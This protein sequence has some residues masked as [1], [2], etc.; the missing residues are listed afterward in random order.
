MGERLAWRT[1]CTQALLV[2]TIC[3]IICVAHI[4]LAFR[5]RIPS[6]KTYPPSL[7]QLV[8]KSGQY[9]H[10]RYTEERRKK[11]KTRRLDFKRT[12]KCN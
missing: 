8:E 9:T 12:H 10:L 1:L 2:G 3:S 11:K 4:C 7:M 6:T 5:T